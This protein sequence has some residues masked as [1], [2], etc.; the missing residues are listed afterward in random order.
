MQ[1]PANDKDADDHIDDAYYGEDLKSFDVFEL[2]VSFVLFE[3][4]HSKGGTSRI[5][6]SVND[7]FSAYHHPTV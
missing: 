1:T 7:L 3:M 5:L 6:L 2:I 4:L